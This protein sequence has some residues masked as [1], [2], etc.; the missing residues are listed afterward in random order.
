M[1]KYFR[2]A[3][4]GC[5]SLMLLCA[6]L[7][8]TPG[9]RA[10]AAFLENVK[11]IVRAN[12]GDYEGMLGVVKLDLFLSGIGFADAQIALHYDQQVLEPLQLKSGSLILPDYE[13]TQNK[14]YFS[15]FGRVVIP[16]KKGPEPQIEYK[17]DIGSSSWKSLIDPTGGNLFIF[18]FG[19][20]NTGSNGMRYLNATEETQIATIYFRFKAGHSVDEFNAQTFRLAKGEHPDGGNWYFDNWCYSAHIT[21]Y[22]ENNSYPNRYIPKDETV[23]SEDTQASYTDASLSIEFNYPNMGQPALQ[24]QG[25]L[26]HAKS[27]DSLVMPDDRAKVL[28]TDVNGLEIAALVTAAPD[29]LSSTYSAYM[30]PGT[31]DMRISKPGHSTQAITR[32]TVAYG[33]ADNPIMTV[34]DI[35]LLAGDMDDDGKVTFFD[36]IH[37]SRQPTAHGTDDD[38]K[39][40]RLNFGKSVEQSVAWN[41][42][43]LKPAP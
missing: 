25:A 1:K 2:Q 4:C 21:Q 3:L 28:F 12:V 27:H 13:L 10:R 22:D 20:G 30:L 24:V 7:A 39:W 42:S 9:L 17:V 40:V 43:M 31:Y 36:A 41:E 5:L 35:D 6:V 16:A 19:I 8:E 15:Q 37:I 18:M 23:W 14:D 29:G 33:A 38:M 26:T 32:V 34:K 11:Y